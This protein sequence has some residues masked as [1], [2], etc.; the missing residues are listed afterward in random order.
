MGLV[1]DF[2]VAGA[3]EAGSYICSGLVILS[4]EVCF[5]EKELH[6]LGLVDATS[7]HF[8]MQLYSHFVAIAIK[9]LGQF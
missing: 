9:V 8:L 6:F 2:G 4:R 3:F 5:R 1:C 7:V